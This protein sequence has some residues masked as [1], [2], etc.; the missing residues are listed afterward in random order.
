MKNKNTPIQYIVLLYA[1]ASIVFL[2]AIAYLGTFTRYM[3]DDY[4]ESFMVTD[5]SILGAVLDRYMNGRW[6]AANRLSNL[7]FVGFFELLGKHNVEIIPPLMILLW[8]IG[9]IWLVYEIRKLARLSWPLYIDFFLGILLAFFSV[10]EAPNRFQIFYWRS[11]M[12]THFVP[13][14]LLNFMLAFLLSNIRSAQGQRKPAWVG[15]LFFF[16]SFII[17]GFSEPPVTVMVVG[18]GLSL[19]YIWY[20]VK[21]EDRR[22]AFHLLAWIFSGALSALLVMAVSPAIA[23]LRGDTPSFSMWVFRTTQYTYLFLIDTFKTLP[24]PTALSFGVPALFF[25]TLYFNKE[26]KQEISQQRWKIN[27]YIMLIAPFILALLIAAGFSPSA[28]GQSF[29]VARARFFAHYLLSATLILEGAF[30]GAWLSQLKF[31]VFHSKYSFGASIFILVV[32]AFYPL[33]A[34]LQVLQNVPAYR[35]R[36]LLWDKRDAIIRDL[37]AQG[38][39]DL[40]IIQFD[41]VDGTK[42]LDVSA[43]HWANGCAAQYYDVHSIRAIPVPPEYIDEYFGE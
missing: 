42:E 15:F 19:F 43:K 10:F 23:H 8:T 40:V 37:K 5:D 21:H 1:L 22:P 29:P 2:L 31:P 3:A 35:E 14:V 38:E 9:L 13:L 6:R 24:I 16:A 25:Y 17:G 28:Y 7:M 18:C 27:F 4:C 12:A 32:L 20:F 33:R 39:T 30:L 41:G 26:N 36:E 34:G 11:S